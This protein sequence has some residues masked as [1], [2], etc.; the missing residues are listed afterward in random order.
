MLQG[1]S[2]HG[3]ASFKVEKAHFAAWERAPENGKNEVKLCTPLCAGP[4]STLWYTKTPCLKH[5]CCCR[6]R[7]PELTPTIVGALDSWS[8]AVSIPSCKKDNILGLHLLGRELHF[9]RHP[10]LVLNNTKREIYRVF[11]WIRNETKI[12]VSYSSEIYAHRLLGLGTGL[13][14]LYTSTKSVFGVIFVM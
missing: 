4:W 11:I 10:H 14:C 2:L 12:L 13:K 9:C 6:R 7:C 8:G 5:G 1:G 3:G